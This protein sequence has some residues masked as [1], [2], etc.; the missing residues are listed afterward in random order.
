MASEQVNVDLTATDKGASKAVDKLA[1]KVD[2]LERHPAEVDL[3]ADGTDLRREV[4]KAEE[5]LQRLD[6][7]DV[8]VA[9]RAKIDG[10]KRDLKEAEGDLEHL[11]DKADDT[12]KHVEGLGG[13]QRVSAIRDLTGPLGDVST[14]VGDFGDSFAAAGLQIESSLGLAEG[15][16]TNLL[17]PVGIGIGL[18][19]SLWSAWKK[20]AEE[21]KK[22]VQEVKASILDLGETAAAVKKVQDK[23]AAD[24]KL[25][26]NAETLGLTF[27]D[28]VDIV[29]GKVVPA[30]ATLKRVQEDL[31]L[32]AAA[33]PYGKHGA[34]FYQQA[35]AENARRLG[36]TTDEMR[37][38]LPVIED[39]TGALEG[40][41]DEFSKGAEAAKRLRDF[42]GRELAPGMADLSTKADTSARSLHDVQ[43][44]L[45]GIDGTTARADVEVTDNGTAAATSRKIDQAAG[46]RT[47]VVHI[48]PDFG[49]FE[50][51]LAQAF[52]GAS[53]TNVN[54]SAPRGMRAADLVAAGHAYARRNGGRGGAR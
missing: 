3:E 13:E 19:V 40:Q 43:L 49:N 25:V 12:G 51:R 38:L 9:L 10:L 31:N 22:K 2:D 18:A 33:S 7:A 17:A 34:D 28:V 8:E 29:S 39:V 1:D 46:D 6:K 41:R 37:D 47:A 36:L 30:Y 20:G 42:Y 16:I 5:S 23:L 27:D 48:S 15:S 24:D 32:A 11:A 4:D 54:I 53:V 26:Q 14:Q 44:E 21:S 35:L 45:H 50:A 52:R